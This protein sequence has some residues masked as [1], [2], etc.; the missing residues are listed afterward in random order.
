V[1]GNNTTYVSQHFIFVITTPD[2]YYVSQYNRCITIQPF[3]S[4]YNRCI[5]IQP[6]YHKT[7]VVSQYNL[8]CHNTTFV[9]QYNLRI[10]IQPSYHNTFVSQFNLRLTIYHTK[11]H[12]T[13]LYHIQPYNTTDNG[14]VPVCESWLLRSVGNVSAHEYLTWYKG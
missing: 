12:T 4:Q 5:T 9:S 10:T 2:H 14:H 1:Y 7:T 11:G 6:L 3:V 8:L 13:P